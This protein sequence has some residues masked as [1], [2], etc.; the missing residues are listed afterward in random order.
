MRGRSLELTAKVVPKSASERRCKNFP[1]GQ[2][3]KRTAIPP[4]RV[5]NKRPCVPAT[6]TSNTATTISTVTAYMQIG[7]CEWA[8]NST[9]KMADKI[10]PRPRDT[11][12]HTTHQAC[13][14]FQAARYSGTSNPSKFLCAQPSEEEG[15]SKVLAISLSILPCLQVFGL[16]RNPRVHP[17]AHQPHRCQVWAYC[18]ARASLQGAMRTSSLTKWQGHNEALAQCLPHQSAETSEALNS[19]IPLRP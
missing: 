1:M 4:N 18:L 3:H 19:R 16:R 13:E 5:P 11:S 8:T 10:C 17:A 9:N 6:G 7:P 12:T 14:I 2:Y 15:F